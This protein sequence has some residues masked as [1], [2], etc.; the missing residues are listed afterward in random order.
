MLAAHILQ[1]PLRRIA[2][3]VVLRRP[4][5]LHDGLGRQRK[6]L[7]LL[8]MHHHRAQHLVGVGDAS[9]SVVLLAAVLTMYAR[10]GEVAGGVDR[11]QIVPAQA[12]EPL[13]P[14][15]AL[16]LREHALEHTTQL[17]GVH[18]VESLAPRR[19]A[20]RALNPIQALQIHPHPLVGAR[21]AVELKQRRILQPEHRQPRHQTITQA[22]PAT[23]HRV[24]DLV[25][26]RPHHAQQPRCAQCLPQQPLGH[27]DSP[28]TGEIMAIMLNSR[29]N[30]YEHIFFSASQPP[31]SSTLSQIAGIAERMSGANS[32]SGVVARGLSGWM[33]LR[34]E[35]PHDQDTGVAGG[36]ADEI[37]GS[38]RGVAG[39]AADA[40]R[41]RPDCWGSVSARCGATW[42][43]T[44]TRGSMGWRT[45][46]WAR[47]RPLSIPSF[48]YQMTPKISLNTRCSINISENLSINGR[49][50]SSGQLGIWSYNIN[51]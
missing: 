24:V 4:V 45:S 3:A 48:I 6:D 12:G 38:V 51:P 44:R 13:Q 34:E 7:A 40:S 16:E 41:R 9:V 25:E 31:D 36:P 42:T 32:L 22:E 17:P 29:S 28:I 47:S 1:Q 14:L 33:G 46:A 15:A 37:Q 35:V 10:R 5:A 19:V 30:V 20:R 49:T 21:I 2:L 18:R 11:E 23:A 27:D 8:G 50:R 39:A 26:A 43:A